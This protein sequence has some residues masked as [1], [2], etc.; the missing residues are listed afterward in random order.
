MS[1]DKTFIGGK[2]P[3]PLFELHFHRLFHVVENH[4]SNVGNGPVQY[5]ANPAA[6]LALIGLVA[7][8]EAFCKHQLAALINA[9]RLLISR[10][11]QRRPQAIML[12]D[13][14]MLLDDSVHNI[15]AVL[16]D[17]YDFGSASMIN[18]LFRDL[19][20]VTPFS[21]DDARTRQDFIRALSSRAS[22]R[23][24]YLALA[25]KGEPS[26]QD[27]RGPICLAI[28]CLFAHTSTTK[29]GEFGFGMAMKVARPSVG[30]APEIAAEAPSPNGH[31][32]RCERLLRGLH[33][34]LE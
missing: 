30:A 3:F 28:A 4:K 29:G 18:G 11:P 22:R 24:S 23:H 19:V 12:R 6:E 25:Q 9:N 33:D 14:A 20:G 2:P 8:V 27:A 32:E 16:A 31:V 15:G 10:F 7:H 13:V 1:S 5:P 21:K 34:S 26:R 17:Q